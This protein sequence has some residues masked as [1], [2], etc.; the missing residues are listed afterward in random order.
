MGSRSAGA[1]E[2]WTAALL[3]ALLTAGCP[4]TYRI[5]PSSVPAD[6][7]SNEATLVPATRDGRAAEIHLELRPDDW[8]TVCRSPGCWSDE[9]LFVQ[10]SDLP[11]D[12]HAAR[13]IRYQHRNPA[14]SWLAA[15]SAT[16][17]ASLTLH[18]MMVAEAGG[19]RMPLALPIVGPL[20]LG[21]GGMSEGTDTFLGP[22]GFI[23]AMSIAALGVAEATGF[24]L[25]LKGAVVYDGSRE[26]PAPAGS[27]VV[28]GVS[29]T[30]GGAG[31]M[32]GFRF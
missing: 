27:Q 26:R 32:L 22:M 17:A 23:I 18:Y 9:D 3:V 15:G 5:A 14:I 12:L 10:V 4:T 29:P 28:F 8:V 24:G 19:D 7:T 2:A 31:A 6:I 1:P 30:P 21:V 16:L 25:L 13:E 11:A 20:F